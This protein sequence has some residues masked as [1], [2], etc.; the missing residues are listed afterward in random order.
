MEWIIRALK[1]GGKAFVIIPDGIL[2]RQN[3]K[4]LRQFI[5]DECYIDG[6]ISLPIKTFFTT[7]KKTYILCITKKTNKKDVQK[8]PVFTYLVSEIGESRDIYRFDIEQDDLK[9][10]VKLYNSYKG[11]KGYFIDNNSDKRCKIQSLE[12]FDSNSHWS[13]D[14]WW[15]KEEQIEIGILNEDETIQI[16]QFSELVKDI[17]DSF[18]EFSELLK[19]VSKKKTLNSNYKNVSLDNKKYFDF[20]IGKR[21]VKKDLVK[22]KGSLPIYSANVFDPIGFHTVSNIE[23]FNNDF[24]IWGID[25]DFG[26]NFI[27]KNKPFVT[28]DHCGTIR[29]LTDEILPEYLMLQLSNVK[30]E[31][32]FD[33]GL[34]SSLKNMEQVSI[35]IPFKKN[36]NI[37]LE[38]QKE[39]LEKYQVIKDL[40]QK[41]KEYKE[42]IKGLNIEIENNFPSVQLKASKLFEI[43]SIPQKISKKDITEI[44]KVPVFSS[45]TTNEGLVGFTDKYMFEASKEKKLITF[46]DHTRIFFTREKNFSVLDNVK[47][48]KLKE[49]YRNLISIEYVIFNWKNKIPSLGYSRHWKEA[50]NI[51]IN[52]PID[53]NGE[54]NLETQ[55]EIANKY[56]K[57]ENIKSAINFE[58]D[59]ISQIKIDL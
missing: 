53:K 44:G 7:P 57:I 10:A 5:L 16:N 8:D 22:I 38:T 34:R 1:P 51:K 25:G 14:R 31:Y 54:F 15:T 32:G 20:F 36:G 12:K 26:F 24:V 39:V 17:S 23:N 50:K 11:S 28:T 9:E 3:D 37:D 19:E 2:N 21:L 58:L 4:N 6:I 43:I 59:K 47:V 18:G 13:V 41:A 45:Q 49:K 29:I 56:Q 27:E 52:I 35:Q 46:G 33:R 55:K 42:K 30:N 48:L 40:K